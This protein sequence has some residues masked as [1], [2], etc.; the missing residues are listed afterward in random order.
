MIKPDIFLDGRVTQFCGDSLTVLKTMPS[1]YYDCVVCSPPY[2][3]LRD[4]GVAG[5]LGLERSLGEHLAV[6]VEVFREVRRVLK[7]SGVLFLNYGDCYATAPNGRSAADTKAA[8]RDDRT[9]RD[10]PFST[11]G[12]VLKAKD[13]A[14]VPNRLAIALQEPFYT[15]AIKNEVD[16][17]W[18]ASMIDG[19]GCI[20]IHRRKAGSSAHSKFRKRDGTDVTYKRTQDSFSSGLEVSN[21][22]EAIIRR[23]IEIT[24][25]GSLCH[26]G[27]N[28]NARRK[29][30]IYR[31][32][33]RSNECRGVLQEV[34]PHLVAK[35]HQARLAISCP[36]SGPQ[37]TAAHLSLI[38]LHNGRQAEIDFPPP[39]S[40]FEQGWW[41]RSEIVWAKPNCMPESTRDRPTSS[42]EKIWLLT[43]RER[44]FYDA[45]AIRE[46][47]ETN[48]PR[49]PYGSQGAWQLDGRPEHQR[50]NGKPRKAGNKNHKYVTA[51]EGSESE[52]H[53]TK[54]GLL[55]V[56]DVSW[57]SR[58]ARNVWTISP[59]PFP[60]AHF[61][62]FPPELAERCIKA[63]SPEGGYVLDP[64]GGAGTTALV[65]ASLG[66]RSTLI[67]LNP[68]YCRLARARIESAFMGKDEG[69]RHMT[70]Q[71]GKIAEPGP[72]FAGVEA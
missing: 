52:E 2:W 70:K 1:D 61:A 69:A 17:A 8:G 6:M 51:Y 29:Q 59:A 25:K 16:R 24:G 53:R 22:N 66:R 31:W 5:Q 64:F 40:M 60:E 32:N 15:G 18:L 71:L 34:Y 33:L 14:M 68:E 55:K 12:G 46:S 49:R 19:E 48:D 50:P 20:F 35:Q 39:A 45:D 9:F 67:E 13:L 57:E 30:K 65:A 63:G 23:C 36:S 38:S 72:L 26:Q 4:Y 27:P 62:T 10:K 58:N 47:S 37:A 28:E 3:G 42:H 43:K 21:T 56:A 7:P 54:A 41:V 11:V 44:Y